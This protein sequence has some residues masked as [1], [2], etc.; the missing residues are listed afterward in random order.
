M[1]D[2]KIVSQENFLERHANKWPGLAVG[3]FLAAFLSLVLCRRIFQNDRNEC[4]VAYIFL[5]LL[6]AAFSVVTALRSNKSWLLMSALATGLAVQGIIA[7][8]IE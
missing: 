5:Q 2:E 4:F 8:L 3:S 1:I 6:S 7:I